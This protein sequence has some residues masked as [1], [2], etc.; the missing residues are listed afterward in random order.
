MMRARL[1]GMSVLF[2][3]CLPVFA[4]VTFSIDG[5]KSRS[6]ISPYIY[7]TNYGQADGWSGYTMTRVGGNRLTAYNWTNNASNAGSDWHFQNDNY[8]GGGNTPGG[9]MSPAINAA[10]ANNAALLL[11]IPMNGYVSA[12]KLG[13]GDVRYPNGDTTKAQDPNYLSTRFRPEQARKG[14]AFTL[15]PSPNSPVVYQDE[16]VNWVKQTYPASQ[17]DP[18]KPIWYALDNE[19]DL[20]ASTHAEVHPAKTTYAEMVQKT[21]AYA[22]AIKDVSPNAKVFGPVNYGWAGYRSLQSAPDAAGRDFH[23]FYLQQLHAAEQTAG[24][25]LVDVMD[26]HYYSEAQD[27]NGHRV[28]DGYTD[29]AAVAARVQAARSL[30][31]PSYKET[32]WITQWDTNGGGIDLVHRIQAKIDANN[33][34]MQVGITEYNLGGGNHISGAIAEAEALGAFGKTK[35]FAATYWQLD[36]SASYAVGA[37]KMYRDFDGAGGQFGDTSVEAATSN[38]NQSAIFASVDSAD[39]SKI[40]LIA[41]NRTGSALPAHFNLSQLGPLLDGKW[42]QLTS[43]GAD[44]SYAGAIAFGSGNSFDLSLPAYSV[45]T[46]ALTVAIP[47]PTMVATVALLSGAALLRRRSRP[48]VQ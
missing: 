6:A 12:D 34:G 21:V 8:L 40:T 4:D 41:I 25:R 27:T 31:D 45:N 37:L 1:A 20:W 43:A 47:E 33:P 28:T 13:N 2:C 23:T 7:G 39:P 32:S 10:A 3:A 9:A 15:T 30:Y 48:S 11:T 14:S 17:T 38:L 36:S 26:V 35:V 29:S 18:K 5:S 44:P 24:R 22:S 16:F 19:P 42:Y 46:L